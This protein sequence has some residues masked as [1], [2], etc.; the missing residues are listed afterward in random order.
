M[1]DEQIENLPDEVNEEEATLQSNILLHGESV[2][3]GE[4][5]G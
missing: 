3:R 4:H 5:V 2:P 1:S